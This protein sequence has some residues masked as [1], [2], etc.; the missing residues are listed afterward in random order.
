MGIGVVMAG[1]GAGVWAALHGQG[2]W[3]VPGH[4][5]LRPGPAGSWLEEVALQLLWGP[6]PA[7]GM[8]LAGAA[9]P[10]AWAAVWLRGYLG[11]LAVAAA[12]LSG[13][14]SPVRLVAG[15]LVPH[16]LGCLAAL[17]AALGSFQLGAATMR[18]TVGIRPYEL[19]HA[20]G[21]FLAAG[22]IGLGLAAVAG[23][24]RAAVLAGSMAGPGAA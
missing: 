18:A 4:P 10:L 11:G 24:L 8:G 22:A 13:H 23:L 20:F 14:P 6:G 3:S 2:I 7:W 17:V 16:A 1:A 19:P 12:F 15:S 5:W 21:R 9:A